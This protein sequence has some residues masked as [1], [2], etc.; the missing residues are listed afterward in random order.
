MVTKKIWMFT[1]RDQSLTTC[2]SILKEFKEKSQWLTDE[3]QSLTTC[4]SILKDKKN[5]NGS[6]MRINP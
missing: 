4:T 1:D 6:L 2:T 3:D 5:P